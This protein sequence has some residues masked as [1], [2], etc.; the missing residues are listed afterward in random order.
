MKL[1]KRILSFVMAALMLFSCMAVSASAD[2]ETTVTLVE[3]ELDMEARTLKLNK[4]VTAS[5]WDVSF[6]MSPT[7]T[8]APTLLTETDEAFFYCNLVSGTTYNITVI[9][10]VEGVPM[11]Q[12][13]PLK[14]LKSQNAPSTPVP[15]KITTTSIEVNVVSGCEY[16]CVEKGGD[17]SS[18]TTFSNLL[19]GTYYTI[20]MRYKETSTHYAS[21]V[22]TTTIRT[23]ALPSEG[24]PTLPEI[25][26]F[27]VDKTNN[28]ITVM[29]IDGVEFSIDDGDNWQVS[30]HFSG[31]TADTT[32]A[33]IAR[34]KF[35]ESVQAPNPACA[36]VEIRTNVRES[37]PASINNCKFAASEGENYANQ[38]ISIAVTA[39]TPAKYHDTQFGDTKYI[40]AYYTIDDDPTPKLFTSSDGKVFKATFTPGDAK[41]N[42]KISINV[43][44][45]K[46][47][48]VGEETDGDAKWIVDGKEESKT[49]YVQVGES[50]TSAT[51]F[52]DFFL[53][54]FNFLFNTI[55]AKINELIKG[56]DLNSIMG[57][58][59]EIFKMLGDI[60]GEGVSGGGTGDLS[61]LLGNLTQQ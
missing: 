12:K 24:V 7:T 39:D 48:C 44:Y 50:Y 9:A 40:P 28:S 58:M 6:E 11:T 26:Y 38:P 16:R 51:K 5:G 30:G 29:E 60:S 35:D 1:T 25:E 17:F 36:P 8:A 52:R 13:I 47:K 56:I 20:E 2:S 42:K 41:A 32:Y 57:G 43:Y 49:Y 22:S 45:N 23:L 59:N 33:V 18:S 3:T 10:V 27:L 19:P 34:F 61:D 14:L 53:E 55:P 54:I 37:Y 31:L 46:M 4:L 21:P 15:K